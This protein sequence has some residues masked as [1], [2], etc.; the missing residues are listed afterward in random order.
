M[1]NDTYLWHVTVT[2]AGD[3]QDL[4]DTHAAL[5]R[6]QRERPFIH[7]L[8]YAEERAEVRYWEE[9]A[10]MVDAASLA[11]RLWNEHR[12]SAQLPNWS[13]VGLEVVTEDT[14]RT[15][16]SSEPRLAASVAPRRF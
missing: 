5:V 4:S 1:T 2:V 9:S 15:R 13:V 8:R 11:L 14:Y 16:E 3:P 12:T 7:S 6:L 10:D